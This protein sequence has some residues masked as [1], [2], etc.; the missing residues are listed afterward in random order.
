MDDQHHLGKMEDTFHSSHPSQF[1]ILIIKK[2]KK[3]VQFANQQ[4]QILSANPDYQLISRYVSSDFHKYSNPIRWSIDCLFVAAGF[5]IKTIWS[6]YFLSW[7]QKWNLIACIVY[8]CLQELRII[9][10]SVV[11][12]IENSR[13]CQLDLGHF[14]SVIGKIY[15][16]ES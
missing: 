14:F 6:K 7:C 5:L 11:N 13:C 15:S 8:I 10:F 9:S 2:K 3:L 16:K 12:L 4:C 1:H